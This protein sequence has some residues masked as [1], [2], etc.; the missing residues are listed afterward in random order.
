MW[1][2]S[3]ISDVDRLVVLVVREMKFYKKSSPE[4]EYYPYSYLYQVYDKVMNRYLDSLLD[5]IETDHDVTLADLK[6]SMS[7]DEFARGWFE[8]LGDFYEDYDGKQAE[9]ALEEVERE[10]RK[11]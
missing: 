8:W 9:L 4:D 10:W 7:F 2:V 11:L 1:L 5:Q 3:H 6:R